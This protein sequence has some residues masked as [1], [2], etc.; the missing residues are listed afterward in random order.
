MKDVQRQRDAV[1]KALTAPGQARVLRRLRTGAQRERDAALEALAAPGQAHDVL[2]RLQSGEKLDS[3]YDHFE[4]YGSAS[5]TTSQLSDTSNQLQNINEEASLTPTQMT[6]DSPRTLSHTNSAVPEG[7]E[8]SHIHSAVKGQDSVS[9]CA[10]DEPDRLVPHLQTPTLS[11]ATL[12]NGIDAHPDADRMPE[13]PLGMFM[14]QN[15]P[16]IFPNPYCPD[17]AYP[18]DSIGN[19]FWWH[20]DISDPMQPNYGAPPSTDPYVGPYQ[21][22]TAPYI[23]SQGQ[24]SYPQ[25]IS[26][27]PPVPDKSPPI[28]RSSSQE[29][30]HYSAASSTTTTTIGESRYPTPP[31]TKK[32]KLPTRDNVSSTTSGTGSRSRSNTFV[33]EE[34]TANKKPSNQQ[35]SSRERERHRRASARNW[36]RQKQQTAELEAVMKFAESRN[37]EL[38]REY[39]EVLRQV[40]DV[41]NALMD[42]A[43]CNNPG[44]NSWLHSQATNIHFTT[45]VNLIVV[46]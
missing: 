43:K 24:D 16:M 11:N 12:T 28:S 8:T 37:R 6:I 2:R 9:N 45:A 3:I 33:P 46:S 36:Q 7:P 34:K 32:R 14:E 30:P 21:Q 31:P 17:R 13:V 20:S 38:H 5:P 40:V 27:L 4:M 15:T 39:A 26:T 42:H 18:T 19:I 35:H 44:I 25:P 1:L 41:K 23:P 22:F 29:R 10:E